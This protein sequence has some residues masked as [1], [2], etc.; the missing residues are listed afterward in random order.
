MQRCQH[1]GFPK[2]EISNF[3]RELNMNMNENYRL[4]MSEINMN[5][6]ENYGSKV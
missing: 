1:W 6:R 3:G 5:K 2:S 4:K